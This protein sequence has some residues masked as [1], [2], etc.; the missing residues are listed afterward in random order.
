MAQS[1][2]NQPNNIFEEQKKCFD[3][4][5]LDEEMKLNMAKENIGLFLKL[6]NC[7]IFET[8]NNRHFKK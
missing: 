6:M 2:C 3:N 4:N 8:L 7:T 1:Y 5:G